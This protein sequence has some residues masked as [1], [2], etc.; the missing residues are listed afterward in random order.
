MGSFYM[1]AFSFA[2][3]IVAL[4]TVSGILKVPD[5][6]HWLTTIGV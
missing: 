1:H 6:S 5:F 2:L 3:F 4:G